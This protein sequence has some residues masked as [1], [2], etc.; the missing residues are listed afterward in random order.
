MQTN[1]QAIRG[2]QTDMTKKIAAF[3]NFTNAPQN[4]EDENE[5]EVKYCKN[6]RR[7]ENKM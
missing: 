1:R 7:T 5:D 4:L 2:R 6:K 3:S